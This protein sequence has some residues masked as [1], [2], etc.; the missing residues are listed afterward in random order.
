M[1]VSEAI[2]SKRAVRT[3]EDRPIAEDQVKKILNAG[4][5]AQSAKNMQPWHFIAIREKD[6]LKK[7]SELGHYAGHLAGAVLGVALI[8]PPPSQRF[9]VMFD[10]GQA[11]AYMQLAAWEMGIGSCL[12]T[13]YQPEEARKL[14]KFPDDLEINIAISFGYPTADLAASRPARKQGR[15]QFP[16]V[17]HYEKW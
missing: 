15:R 8:T 2:K 14:L 16:E 4:R 1:E 11:A 13:I 7:L 3:F 9:S 5:R 6:T 12:A 10:T 17:V